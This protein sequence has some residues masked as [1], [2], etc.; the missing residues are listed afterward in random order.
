M[1]VVELRSGPAVRRRPHYKR[2]TSPAQQGAADRMGL[3]S[4]AW[5][6]LGAAQAEAW[7]RYAETQ[8]RHNSIDGEAYAMTGNTA[9]IALATKFLQVNP[10]GEIPTMPPVA[11]FVGDDVLVSIAPSGLQPPPP[12]AHEPSQTGEELSTETGGK[13]SPAHEPSQV[14]EAQSGELSDARVG[15][16]RPHPQPPL[17]TAQTSVGRGGSGILFTADRPNREGVTTELVVQKLRSV[18]SRPGTRYTTAKFVEFKPGHL[19]QMVEVPP[20]TWA[21]AIRF[22]ETASG[23]A[24]GVQP[25]AV[26]S[27]D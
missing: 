1:V 20:G 6:S 14:A 9:F 22:V 25:I 13:R 4:K 18:R 7:H 15:S 27:I 5:A 19:D 17:P 26:V 23:R 2:P 21:C 10:G 3:A 24:T 8:I 16:T 12:L 11:G